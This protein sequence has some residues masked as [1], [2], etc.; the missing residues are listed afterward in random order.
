MGND[1]YRHVSELRNARSDAKAVAK[2]LEAAGFGVTVRYDL[3]DKALKEALRN[4]KSKVQGGDDAVFYFSG[5]G[6][7]LGVAN[8]LLPVDI[9]GE[10]EDQVKDDALPLQRVLDDL[11]DQK[12]RFTL[13]IV[14]A[15][16]NNPFKNKGRTIGGRGLVPVNPATGQM[17]LYS[18]GAG[19]QALDR[20][21]DGDRDP[22]GLFTRVLLKEMNR[23]G[24]SVDR[25]LRNVRDQVVK[26]AKNV[27]HDQV[28]ALYDQAI[29]DF[30][31]KRGQQVT[32]DVASPEPSGPDAP[33][34]TGLSL[35]AIQAEAKRR[36]GWE[37]WQGRMR[38]DYDQVAALTVAPDLK[39]KAWADWF[40]AYKEENPYSEEDETLRTQARAEL[41]NAMQQVLQLADG[42]ERAARKARK[43]A[44]SAAG[45]RDCPD[46]P[47]MVAIPGGSFQMGSPSVEEWRYDDEGP[48]HR[49]SVEGFSMSK[50]EIT[51]GQFAAFVNDS[52]HG[53]GNS[54]WVIENG[55]WTEKSCA[56]WRNLNF[57]QD[58]N[59]PVVC[60]N[61]RD[62]Q[63]YTQWL[64]RK[65]GKAYRLATEAEWEYA[66]RGGTDTA[67]PW[68]D[69]AA[70]ACRHANVGDRNAKNLPGWKWE[71]H[72]CDDGYAYT[73][74]VAS[75][76]ANAFSLHDMIGNAWEWVEDCWHDNYSGAQGDGSS[77]SSGSCEKR[78]LRG[79]S[80]SSGPRGA[81]SAK[82]YR[83]APSDRGGDFGFRVVSAAR[84][85]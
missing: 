12:A 59:H 24:V 18:A 45:G 63:A 47:D 57:S 44:G 70:Q 40:A 56:N 69:S 82:R 58:D 14:D 39:A 75:Y 29:G 4:F 78:V 76:T 28:P 72:D 60:V 85:N 15:C 42:A 37:T 17:V 50:T 48:Q 64:S 7:Q 35:Q 51:R 22:N 27:Q 30:Y 16:R 11:S 80:W 46:C 10:N 21:N 67:R 36:A 19:Q 61:W 79:A 23:P 31:F 54:C 2:A 77:W 62:A 26:L 6:V 20:L 66:A 84:T 32:D 74:P 49:V 53:A 1:S 13:A 8:F 41:E 83:H 5:H 68:G 3:G 25:V 71:T 81:R 52:G 38:A 55:A 9:E 33:G 73:A 43:L 65:T 34:G